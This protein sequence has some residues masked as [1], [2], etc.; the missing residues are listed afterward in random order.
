MKFD[1]SDE[2]LVSV[3]WC[4]D[5]EKRRVEMF[6]EYLSFD[7]TFGLNRLRRSLF[8]AVG[9]DGYNKVFVA[10]RAWM[11]SK[12][13]SAFYWTIAQAMPHLFG[14]SL[15]GKHKII[16]SDS[17]LSLVE[18][19]KGA[20]NTPNSHFSN[21]KFRSDYFHFFELRWKKLIGLIDN[22]KSD[23]SKNTGYIKYWIKTW[24]YLIE[25]EKEFRSSFTELEAFIEGKRSVLGQTFIIEIKKILHTIM[26]AKGDLLH[27][28]FR[29]KTSFGFL[30]SSIVEAMNSSIKKSGLFSI[31]G[32]MTLSHSTLLQM[33]QTE[34]R[35]DK[36]DQELAN[37]VNQCHRYIKVN[38]DEYLTK[39][40]LDIAAKNFDGRLSYHVRK[41]LSTEFWVMRKD[42]HEEP[43][44]TG[45]VSPV[46]KFDKVHVV[47]IVDQFISCSCGY[48]NQYMCPCHHVL[49]VLKDE[50]NLS[51][52]LYHYRW[53]KQYDYF[54][55]RRCTENTL[56][57]DPAIVA[58][59]K[60]MKAWISFTVSNAF[61][62]NGEY[63]GCYLESR[64]LE[65]LLS[66]D[67]DE[68]DVLNTMRKLHE[69][70]HNTGPVIRHSRVFDNPVEEM[71]TSQN[72]QN[73]ELL[74]LQ[75]DM[76]MESHLSQNWTQEEN[77]DDN[78][79]GDDDME[80]SDD[81]EGIISIDANLNLT[82]RG[83]DVWNRT[84]D[85]LDCI[86]TL[87]DADDFHKL[88]I[89]F[90]SK[91]VGRNVRGNDCSVFGA[92]VSNFRSLSK[93]RYKYLHE[94]K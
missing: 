55:L 57:D 88:L 29:M 48:V 72:S 87:E 18:A 32:T 7:T 81:G 50:E 45:E 12:Q 75:T 52:T 86:Q 69:Y 43:E 70:T 36:R 9:T 13:K 56:K 91:I 11:P 22:S 89:E 68:D 85:V 44:R 80:H 35:S 73:N 78:R 5:E 26:S 82:E 62:D 74:P 39:Y 28:E 92:E 37:S 17:E 76:T 67:F 24:F 20:I 40:M 21:A 90:K 94:G 66:R 77:S 33:K 19:I 23:F 46:T 65:E 61:Y 4:H 27:F 54:Y 53:W 34:M 79:F 49:A 16:S 2:I 1:D 71:L 84:M 42:I 38:I 31:E 3:A 41:V 59:N 51:Y 47:T 30:G 60:K 6:P 10:F 8:L 15:R 25:T 64:V 14:E 63:K 58:M 83:S 93:R